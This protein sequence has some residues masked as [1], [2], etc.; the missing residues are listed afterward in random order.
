MVFRGHLRVGDCK[1]GHSEGAMG[2]AWTCVRELSP[3]GQG[4]ACAQGQA[5]RASPGVI[6]AC[7]KGPAASEPWKL[8]EA[9]TQ[10]EVVPNVITY[11]ALISACEKGKQWEEALGLLKEM[12]HQ[13]LTPD[14]VSYNAACS[15]AFSSHL[16]S[17]HFAQA[18]AILAHS[19]CFIS[20]PLAACI[21]RIG[22]PSPHDNTITNT[23][24]V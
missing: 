1:T 21:G 17:R 9:M 4:T 6:S 13:L 15:A 11:S 22:S 5:A 2:C 19:A 10:Q 12:V 20:G 24:V 23:S 14:V 16:G 18:Q 3:S 8:F 7:E